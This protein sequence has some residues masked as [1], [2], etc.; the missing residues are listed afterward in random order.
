MKTLHE[1]IRNTMDSLNKIDEVAFFAA[2]GGHLEDII[3]KKMDEL[4]IEIENKDRSED[5]R[6]ISTGILNL[7]LNIRRKERFKFVDILKALFKIL[8]N[9]EKKCFNS[10][11]RHLNIPQPVN[12]KPWLSDEDMDRLLQWIKLQ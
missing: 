1:S 2:A 8:R 9:E 7:C 10:V 11:V 6:F 12:D 3:Q 5:I 4:R